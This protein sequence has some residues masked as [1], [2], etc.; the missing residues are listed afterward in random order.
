MAKHKPKPVFERGGIEGDAEIAG[1]VPTEP[2]PID[3]IADTEVNGTPTKARVR[4]VPVD[5][6]G[7]E[8][9]VGDPVVLHGVVKAI[10]VYGDDGVN[11]AV[12]S[13]EP[14]YPATTLTI[15]SL[16]SRQVQKA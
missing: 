7:V 13:V 6:S 4:I 2:D 12:E 3:P 14:A 16:N 5:R 8:L 1:D 11:L 9:K 10:D 15:W